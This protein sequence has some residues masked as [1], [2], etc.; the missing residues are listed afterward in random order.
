MQKSSTSVAD[1]VKDFSLIR[2]SKSTKFPHAFM[3]ALDKRMTGILIGKEKM[4]E[5][6]EPLVKRTFA[7]FLNEFKNPTFRKSMEQDRRVEDLLLIFFSNA[8]KELQKGKA[9]DDDGWRLMVDRHVALFIRLISSILKDHDWA[10]DRPELAS[11]L[12]TMEK[13]L[14]VHDQDLTASSQRNGGSGGTTI[15]VEVPR[16]YEVKDMPLV[17]SLL[18]V[19]GKHYDEAQADI[20]AN[21]SVWTEKA[22]LDDLKRYQTNLSLE[23]GKTLARH[24]FEY[25]D[26]Y[27]AWKKTEISDV[28]QMLLAIVQSNLEL[29]KST[30]SAGLP[31]F[32]PSTSSLD[33]GYA[34][35]SRKL[36]DPAH[37]SSSYVIDQPVDVSGLNI[38]EPEEENSQYTFI[39][40]DPRAFYRAVVKQALTTD[41]NNPE[42]ERPEGARP[43]LSKASTEILTEAAIRW[44]VPQFSRLVLF[45]D[46]IKEKYQ[47][48]EIDLPTLDSAFEYIKEPQLDT[49]HKKSNRMSVIVQ[50]N[51]FDRSRWS[52]IDN[53]LNKNILSAVHDA[54]LRD[55]FD[56]MTHA[57]DT[58]GPSFG[59]ILGI[60]QA[61]IYSD[62]VF[63]P[64]EEDLENF[65]QQLRNTLKERAEIA[66]EGMLGKVLPNSQEEWEFYH[67]MQLGKQVL[68]LAEKIQK[69]FRK[70]PP[71]VG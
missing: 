54:L 51:L 37:N 36:S 14:L 27:E 35:I 15:E 39:P 31:Q 32:K 8:T 18:G 38:G 33:S 59:M 12:N 58:K 9:A 46:A 34:E 43:L 11:R 56:V 2:D 21:K 41:L 26:A 44:R 24:D 10:R 29:A 60:L 63:Q 20:N 67:I 16:T 49:H 5:F 62:P 42:L 61:H 50:E 64:S 66:Y 13:K 7:V 22:A 53:L 71:T 70:L 48:Q 17:M 19:F 55:F 40:P 23:S 65:W 1:M 28:S 47:H 68:T 4:P 25:E 57:F 69:R 6:H 30:T 52:I 45:L 3:G